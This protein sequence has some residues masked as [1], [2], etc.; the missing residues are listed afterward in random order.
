MEHEEF[1]YTFNH[2]T[3][4]STMRSIVPKLDKTQLCRFGSNNLPY[5]TEEQ[6]DSVQAWL[7]RLGFDDLKEVGW[8]CLGFLS[9]TAFA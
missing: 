2:T 4:I 1:R 5:I 6:I 3:G 9:L 7:H 8:C